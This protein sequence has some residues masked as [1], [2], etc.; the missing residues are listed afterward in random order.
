MSK[1][2]DI[3]SNEGE[4]R[5]LHRTSCPGS[6]LLI[7]SCS[8]VALPCHPAQCIFCKQNSSYVNSMTL[9]IIQPN[10]NTRNIIVV[11]ET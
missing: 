3:F 11:T 6:G 10:R 7:P 2:S 5:S 4:E 9:P 1:Y 8:P